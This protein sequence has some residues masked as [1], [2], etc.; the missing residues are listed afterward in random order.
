LIFGVT[1]YLTAGA[2]TLAR[3]PVNAAI[4]FTLIGAA[5][6]LRRVVGPARMSMPTS[7]LGAGT[8][9]LALVAVVGH[10]TDLTTA[11]GWGL[12][13][14]MAL[15]SAVGFVLAGSGLA[16]RGWRDAPTV[17]A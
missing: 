13:T 3:M 5:L 15:H 14:S 9:A 16:A 8:A 12:L 17:T 7:F 4:C 2:A 1:V 6:F 11:Y 10:L